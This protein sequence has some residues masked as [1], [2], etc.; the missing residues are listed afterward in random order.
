MI[1]QANVLGDTLLHVSSWTT[2]RWKSSLE[3]STSHRCSRLSKNKSGIL[4]SETE[5]EANHGQINSVVKSARS[6]PL[7][8]NGVRQRFARSSQLRQGD[9]Y[10]GDEGVFP[11][12]TLVKFKPKPEAEHDY[13]AGGTEAQ[14]KAAIEELEREKQKLKL[15][16]NERKAWDAANCQMPPFMAKLKQQLVK[17]MKMRFPVIRKVG[18]KACGRLDQRI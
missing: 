3:M 12:D 16:T 4:S 2:I 9:S 15:S 10:L 7:F 11:E 5:I 14:I 17:A 13:A 6:R 18:E 1:S 8:L